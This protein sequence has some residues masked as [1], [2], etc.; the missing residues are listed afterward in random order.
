[1][2]FTVY[3]SDAVDIHH[4]FP[5]DYCVKAGYPRSKWNSIM[6]KTP[7]SY[8]T[9]R[10]IGGVSPSKYLSKIEKKG[11]VTEQV[12]NSYLESHWLDVADCRQDN[13][14][15]FIVKRASKLLD[16]IESVMGKPVSG[17]DS[18]EVILGFG[19]GL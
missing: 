18:E 7:L 11:Q 6:N 3:K 1:M 8:R 10:E 16:A 13:F 17:R 12:L 5:K 19:R 15:E 9:N 4:V 14:D 2:D